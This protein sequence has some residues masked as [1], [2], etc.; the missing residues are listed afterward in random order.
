[1]P[2]VA[3]IPIVVWELGLGLWLTFKGFKST[4]PLMIAAAAH[5]GGPTGPATAVPSRPIVATEAGAA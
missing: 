1:V 3:T 5:S 4:A 2:G